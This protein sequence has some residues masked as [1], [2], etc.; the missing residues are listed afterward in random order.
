[1]D[2]WMRLKHSAGNKGKWRRGGEKLR[3]HPRAGLES[4]QGGRESKDMGDT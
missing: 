3:A 4:N 2:R 1:M